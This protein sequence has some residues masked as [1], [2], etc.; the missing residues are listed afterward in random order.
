MWTH[1]CVLLGLV[2]VAGT[3]GLD[4]CNEYFAGTKYLVQNS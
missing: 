2:Y 1:E 3:K 4:E